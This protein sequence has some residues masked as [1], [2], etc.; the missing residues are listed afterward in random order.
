MRRLRDALALT[1]LA[2]LLHPSA[3]DAQATLAG[4]VRDNTGAILPGVTVDAAPM[5]PAG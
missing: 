2:L 1:V 4:V 5:M 3:A